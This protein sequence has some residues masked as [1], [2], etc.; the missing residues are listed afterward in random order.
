MACAPRLVLTALPGLPVAR[1]GDDLVPLLLAGLDAAG[2]RL[3]DG[4]VIA[5]TSK[6]V[7]RA[8][9]RYA[10]LRDVEPS[11][12]ATKMAA[13][14][15]KDPRLVELILR[16][17]ESISRMAP[18]VLIV[19]HRLGFT[20]ANAGIDRSNVAAS[21]DRDPIVLL[22]PVA[23]DESAAR[24]RE[25]LAAATGAAIGVVI[26]DSHG[27]PFR[28]GTVGT[29]IGVAGMPALWDQRGRED[30]FG[31]RLEITITALA[32][33]V[34]AA[35][36]LLSGQAAEGRPAVH[37][38]GLTFPPADGRARDLVRP[39]DQDLYC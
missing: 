25:G 37:M 22:L 12:R 26:T 19:R 3:E 23:P 7:S 36:D 34:A 27:R 35:A 15:R 17:S 33:Q 28:L 20:V 4:D 6:L 11:A 9:G 38:R 13:A 21:A 31:R 5:V 10:D 30:L 24:L 39:R 32:D 2:L 14:V 8:E 29:A 16:E 18:D 1:P